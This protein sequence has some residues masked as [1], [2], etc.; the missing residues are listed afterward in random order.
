MKHVTLGW[1]AMALALAMVPISLMFG[2][3]NRDSLRACRR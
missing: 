3:G 1:L 2:D